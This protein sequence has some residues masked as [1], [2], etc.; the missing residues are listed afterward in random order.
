MWTLSSRIACSRSAA[1]SRSRERGLAYGDGVFRRCRCSDGAIPIR[2]RSLAALRL[3]ASDWEL[4]RVGCDFRRRSANDLRRPSHSIVKLIV[5]RG[6]AVAAIERL[7]PPTVSYFCTK[8][9]I[10]ASVAAISIPLVRYSTV[11]NPQLAASSTSIRLEHVA[12]QS[13]W[14]DPAIAED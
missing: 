12:A 11:R 8:A 9:W 13:E 4:R 6:P 10:R 1:R 3:A 14:R 5:T 2:R 7:T